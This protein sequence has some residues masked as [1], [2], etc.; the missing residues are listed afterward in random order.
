MMA[1][2]AQARRVNKFCSRT[3]LKGHSAML[4][5]V[6]QIGDVVM[7]HLIHDKKGDRISY[8]DSL[9]IHTVDIDLSALERSRHVLGWCS[10]MKFY[11][12]KI[13][14]TISDTLILIC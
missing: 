5:P 10:E 1:G 14:I 11:G 9:D 3:I 2:L 7:W 8:N 12:G 13:P 4:L 6:G